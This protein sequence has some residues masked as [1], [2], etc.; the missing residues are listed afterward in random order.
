MSEATPLSLRAALEEL[1]LVAILR[2]LVPTE[3]VAVGRVL[4]D[5]GIRVIEVPLNS[6]DPLASI[7][8]L[9]DSFGQDAVLGAGTVLTPDEAASVAETGA[10]LIVA[11][12]FDPSV[13]AHCAQLGLDWVPG[14]LTPT[15]AFGALKAGAA[16]L[17]LF[18]AT[19]SSPAV[20]SGMRA[21]LPKTAL[22]LPVGGVS[23]SSMGPWWEAGASGFGTGGSLFRPGRN[24][25]ELSDRAE[26]LVS[27]VRELQR[28][29]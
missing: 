17:K 13:G 18:P 1:P 19:A 9:V 29:T 4:I 27:A 21:V 28:E 3:A 8:A 5:A 26:R 22:V 24:L 10:R 20:L 16:A 2:G 23:A 15:E 12:N 7:R 11:P 25:D 14:I 6:P